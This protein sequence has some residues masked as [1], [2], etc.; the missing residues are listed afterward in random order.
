MINNRS[1]VIIAI[2]AIVAWIASACFFVV[3][4]TQKAVELRFGKVVENN[5]APGLHVKW[6]V[7]NTV[8]L[9]DG[10]VQTMENTGNTYETSD[11]N[12]LGIDSNIKWRI[13]DPNR[14]FNVTNGNQTRAESLM[15][16][17]VNDRLRDVFNNETVVG[18]V[19][20]HYQNALSDTI[21]QLNDRLVKEVG[22]SL[23]DIQIE[24]VGVSSKVSDAIYQRMNDARVA[25]ARQYRSQAKEEARSIRSSADLERQVTLANA[26][27]QGD[28]LRAEGD[29]RAAAI[30]ASAY[31]QNPEFFRF[32]GSLQAYKKSFADRHSV[33][34]L[35]PSS[36]FF[37][38][39]MNPHGSG[40][41]TQH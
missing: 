16:S 35:G 13:A 7:I 6:P 27:Q 41:P 40:N 21:H 10:R 24:H 28:E 8:R 34:V 2:L 9:F 18:I 39:L 38:Y 19:R 5:I 30:Y 3:S 23:L 12:E 11:G 31:Q 22:I 26:Q 15:G 37:Q 17:M 20:G 1:L 36:N 29:A 25:E 14:L 4:E 32:Y 33:M